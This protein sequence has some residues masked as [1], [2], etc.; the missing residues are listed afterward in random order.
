MEPESRDATACDS[1]RSCCTVE[2]ADFGRCNITVHSSTQHNVDA[3]ASDPRAKMVSK[4][5]RLRENVIKCVSFHRYDEVIWNDRKEYIYS[6]H[7]V[8][9]EREK[10]NYDLIAKIEDAFGDAAYFFRCLHKDIREK[11]MKSSG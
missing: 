2:F 1:A 9:L 5:P 4:L 3:A 8:E 10:A 7:D 11:A 6:L